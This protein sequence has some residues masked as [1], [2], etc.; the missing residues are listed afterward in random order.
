MPDR[1]IALRI[2]NLE[3]K[4]RLVCPCPLQRCAA[5]RVQLKRELR[6]QRARQLRQEA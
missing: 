1:A 6:R 3:A 5:V 4:L 2:R